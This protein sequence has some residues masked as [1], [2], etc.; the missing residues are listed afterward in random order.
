MF[1]QLE[2]SFRM[3]FN[4]ASQNSFTRAAP[5]TAK[6]G[7]ASSNYPFDVEPRVIAVEWRDV[8]NSQQPFYY[9]YFQWWTRVPS[10]VEEALCPI[11]T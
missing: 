11:L 1:W 6:A 8:A 9:L 7:A 5:A 4:H 10:G 2:H 3:S